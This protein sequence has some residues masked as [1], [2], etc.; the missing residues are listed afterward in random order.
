VVVFLYFYAFTAFL[1]IVRSGRINLPV[2]LLL[3]F[4]AAYLLAGLGTRLLRLGRARS[5]IAGSD[6]APG[7]QLLDQG[8]DLG[9]VGS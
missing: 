2:K 8:A 9:Q 5:E 1:H 3:G 4:F 7:S 6:P